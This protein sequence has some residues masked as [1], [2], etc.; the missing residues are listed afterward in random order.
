M[1]TPTPRKT[2]PNPLVE[3]DCR[4][5]SKGFAPQTR[6][7]TPPGWADITHY[8]YAV[9]QKRLSNNAKLLGSLCSFAVMGVPLGVLSAFADN[10]QTETRKNH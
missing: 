7:Y 5:W 3:G 8:A 10:P 1:D 9:Y 4:E 6:M 2:S